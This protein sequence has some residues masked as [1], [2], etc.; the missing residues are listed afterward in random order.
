MMTA[1]KRAAKAGK[2]SKLSDNK[3]TRKATGTVKWK[4]AKK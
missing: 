3:R 4:R 2:R 1:N